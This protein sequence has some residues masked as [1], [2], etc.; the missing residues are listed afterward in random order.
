MNIVFRVDS[1]KNIG[2]G[3]LI[4]CITLANELCKKKHSVTFIC[5]ALP[6]NLIN[7]AE[8]KHLVRILP[9]I[10]TLQFDDFYLDWLGSTQDQD[11]K[12]TIENMPNNVDLLVVDS[13]ALSEFWHK[14]LRKYTRKIMVIDDLSDRNFDCDILLNQNLGA[15]KGDYQ[16]KVLNN[17]T[18]LLGCE[19]ALLRPEFAQMRSTALEKRKNT[20]NI[21]NILISMGGS[22]NQNLTYNVLQNISNIFNIVVVLGQNSP[23][24]EMIKTYSQD[25]NVEVIIGAS[26]M[27]ELMLNA[28]LAIGT[29]GST[30]WERCCL[31]LPTLLFIV[32]DN[33]IKIAENLER[34]KAVKIVDNLKQNLKLILDD[35]NFWQQMSHE[36]V[37][38]C[39]GLGVIKVVD[40]C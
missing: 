23:H 24:N 16:G 2:S 31:G 35:F 6:G 17:C 21:K 11:A 14:K 39:D 15:N 13:Y 1:S 27:A 29:G 9:L 5:R 25:K 19:Y 18:L 4:R 26:N 8:Q 33:Q 34:L 37:K 36:S 32:A 40:S 20:K 3:H 28:D 30:S 10:K 12:Q 38:I 7:L 22:D